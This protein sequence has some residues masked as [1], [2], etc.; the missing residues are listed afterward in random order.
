MPKKIIIVIS[1]IAIVLPISVLIV[2]WSELPATGKIAK[3]NN[4]QEQNADDQYNYEVVVSS[5]PTAAELKNYTDKKLRIQFAYPT[6]L[7]A[8]E[9]S[10]RSGS[11]ADIRLYNKK[12]MDDLE[13]E[14]QGEC[15]F[16]PP[17]SVVISVYRNSEK[18]STKDWLLAHESG[19]YFSTNF[20]TE[21]AVEEEVQVAGKFA[22][23]Y[24]WNGIGGA[25]VVAFSDD[26]KGLIYIINAGYMSSNSPVRGDVWTII[27]SFSL[28]NK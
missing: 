28:L 8:P 19:P 21:T 24:S 6:T 26:E 22:L 17:D 20:N 5:T 13:C 12:Q 3:V 14:V 10:F 15:P 25:D 4:A 2:L 11:I 23:R 1:L 18:L 16:F 9:V 7:T 27:N